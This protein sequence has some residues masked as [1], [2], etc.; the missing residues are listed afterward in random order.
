MP[1]AVL[2]FL[3]LAP[4][5]VNA[6][7]APG[8]YDT[9]DQSSS[10]TLRDSLHEIIDDHM[11]FPYT[12]SD[13]DTW[14]VLEIADED[15]DD[16]DHIITIY[17]N[18]SF[19]KQGGGND[20]YNR[21][22]TWPK[23]YGF[24]DNGP[25]LNYPY[26]DMHHLF[27]ADPDYNFSRSN[28]PYANCG[29]GCLEEVTETNNERGGFGGAYPGDSN[30]TDG[31]FTQGRWE[32]WTGRRGDVARALLYMDVRYAG[33][34]H[35]LTGAT[36]PDLILTD[37]RN[38]MDQ[39][40]TGDNEPVAY[41]G[42]LSV[43]LQWHEEDPVDLIEFQHHEAVASFQGNRNPFIDHPEWAGCVFEGLCNVVESPCN[44]DFVS[45]KD[46][47]VIV[48][49]TGA[50]D[51]QNLQCALEV[52]AESGYPIVRL[53]ANTYFISTLLVENFKGTF[54][55]N[56][57]VSTVI[58]VMDGSIDCAAMEDS[59]LTSSAIKFVGG[60]PRIRFMTITAA[61]PCSGDTRLQNILHF[62][63]ASAMAESC[64]N[65]VIFGA[66]DRLILEGGENRLA[67]PMVAVLVSAEGNQL[68]GCKD[69]LL[70]TFKLNRSDIRNF[71]TGLQTTMKS[72]AQ[73]DVNFNNFYGNTNAVWLQNTNQNTT[74]TNNKIVA[75]DAGTS[76]SKGVVIRTQSAQAPN[77]TRVVINKNE[78]TISSSSG[79][80]ASAVDGTQPGRVANI[81]V[82]VTNNIFTL[83]GN[84][85]RGVSLSDISNAHVSVNRFTGDG[86]T[87]V[88]VSGSNPVSGW[89]ITANKGLGSFSTA[90]S[91]VFLDHKTSG[92]I[93]GEGQAAEVENLGSDNT[94]LPQF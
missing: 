82:V 44:P 60:E 92:C 46:S 6:Q 8:Y 32:T 50:D 69:T 26:T 81:S 67:G 55:G 89:T 93:V 62:T 9:V 72:G 4:V 91:D 30:W 13:T 57:R 36:E 16:S 66:V 7:A 21:E 88:F 3:A 48:A 20:F 28:K 45:F 84:K 25:D 54:E 10:Q 75:V 27:L 58:E 38:L 35:G 1:G 31:S 51:T 74:I 85:T 78:F 79:A 86:E 87:A 70:G 34:M 22:H 24:P 80:P 2:L 71:T 19:S 94:I 52:A 18:A 41:M 83:G 14:D 47:V 12:S 40:N 63:G 64:A 42:L 29:S 33:G 73:V 43:L 23:S 5:W 39:S 59:G 17:R 56:T 65:D 76:G 11:R 49:P 53:T 15:R 68:G 61:Q 77:T 90:I 37:D